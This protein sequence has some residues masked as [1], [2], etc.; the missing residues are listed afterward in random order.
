MDNKALLHSYGRC[1]MNPKF[2]DRFYEIF[3]GSHPAIGPMFRNT[4]FSKQ[5]ALLK[6]GVSMMVMHANGE[7]FAADSLQRIGK[8]HGPAELN[9]DPNLYQYW[10]DSLMA[11]IKECDKEYTEN[12]GVEWRKIL[13]AG[14]DYIVAHGFTR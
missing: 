3:L 9:I 6:T 11:A 5:K 4:D 10:I 2:L 13:R 8:S 7:A 12:L 14:V 1:T